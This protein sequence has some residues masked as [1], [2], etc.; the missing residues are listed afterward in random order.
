MLNYFFYK[1][2]EFIALNLPI[3]VSYLIAVL[4]SDLRYIF[5]Y[6]D[7]KNVTANLKAIFPDKSDQEIRSI[8]IRTFRNFAKYLVDFFRF[9]N[10]DISYI[11]NN[12]T[13]QNENYLKEAIA[14]GRGVIVITA[15]LGNWELG[16]A[17]MGI[18]GYSLWVVALTHKNKN[19]NDFF[20]SHRRKTNVKIIPLGKAVRE[21]LA[22]LKNKEAVA[23]VCDRDFSGRG[24]VMDFFGRPTILPE[25]PAAFALGAGA[26]ILPTF[27]LRNSNDTFTLKFEK[28]LETIIPEAKNHD[29]HNH[30]HFRRVKEDRLKSLM[31]EYMLIVEDYIRK[32]PDQWFVFRKFWVE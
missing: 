9:P 22:V 3:K 16:G 31:R 23:L 30:F 15:H 28:P 8:R 14:S 4:I 7:R 32:F 24:P 26:V 27:M 12:V 20:D 6:E 11:K 29:P 5:A 1:L 21:C 25:G 2:G 13:L 18:L 10:L 19:V 17:T